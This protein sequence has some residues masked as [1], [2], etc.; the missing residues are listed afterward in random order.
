M[1]TKIPIIVKIL[2]RKIYYNSR[3]F[4]QSEKL[5]QQNAEELH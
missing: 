3:S 4:S 2:V 5:V 1:T